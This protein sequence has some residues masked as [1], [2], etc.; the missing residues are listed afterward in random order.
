MKICTNCGHEGKP[1]RQSSGALAILFFTLAITTTWSLASQ[2]FWIV[3]PFSAI[4]TVLF[5]Y[6]FFTTKCPKCH[7]VA[8]TSKYSIAAR[9]Y[10]KNPSTPTS[11][12]VYSTRDPEAEIYLKE[13]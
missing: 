3:L 12:V 10:L 5:M 9:N 1:E 11:N 7:N 4:S 6:W 2:L 13:G 8:M